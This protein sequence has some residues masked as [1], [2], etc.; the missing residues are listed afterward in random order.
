MYEDYLFKLSS[1]Y[2]AMFEEL[3]AEVEALDGEIDEFE[4]DERVISVKVD[5]ELREHLE[6][7]ISE[8]ITKYEKKRKEIIDSDAFC[9]VKLILD[10]L[11]N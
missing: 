2:E 8:L 4:P 7:I 3:K 11:D 1:L 10:G 9:G 6:G 5:P